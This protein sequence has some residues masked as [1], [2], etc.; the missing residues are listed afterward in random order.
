MENDQNFELL[1]SKQKRK[2]KL[3]PLCTSVPFLLY[4]LCG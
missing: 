4:L 1:V 2:E 3:H